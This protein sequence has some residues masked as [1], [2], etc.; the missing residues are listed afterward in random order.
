MVGGVA[1]KEKEDEDKWTRREEMGK[2]NDQDEEEDRDREDNYEKGEK[3][4]RR[5]KRRTFMCKRRKKMR[6]NK[7]TGRGRNGGVEGGNE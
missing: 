3:E 1:G 7:E 2:K 4:Q 5:W 6:A